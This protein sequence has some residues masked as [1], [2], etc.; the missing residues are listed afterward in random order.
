[1]K[2]ISS[3]KELIDFAYTRYKTKS[4]ITIDNGNTKNINYFNYRYDIYS[5]ARAIK[6]KI[7]SKNVAIIS[8]N[9][10]EFLVT[11]LS[12]MMLKNRVILID[13]KLNQSQI[14]K[15]LKKYNINSVFFSNSNEVKV[16]EICS[17]L[18]KKKLNLV[19]FD[20]NSKFPII[21]YEKLINIGRYMEN[22]SIDNISGSEDNAK[23]IVIANL[24]GIREFRQE[25][26]IISANIIGNFIKL[27]KKKE[28]KAEDGIDNFYK[29]VVKIILP[30]LYGLNVKFYNS[31]CKDIKEDLKILQESKN[32][33]MLYYKNSKYLVQNINVETYLV[34]VEEMLTKRNKK[35][36][37]NFVLIKSNKKVVHNLAKK[38]Y[39]R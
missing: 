37:P 25:D 5:L 22:Y 6:S 30:L 17:S 29:V 33:C 21:E 32:K 24:E 4:A 7:K 26:F 23:N 19:N 18:K 20:S 2:Q 16:L 36:Y 31:E 8:E 3:T 34:K 15:I 27:R 14:S 13:A 39:V 28:I 11:L 1:M 9:R 38:E 12:N 35:E 10:Y